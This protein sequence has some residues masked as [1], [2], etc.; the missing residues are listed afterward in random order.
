MGL[1]PANAT[2]I[3]GFALTADVTNVFSTSAQVTGRVFAADHAAPTPSNLIVAVNDMGLAYDDA[4]ARVPDVVGLGAAGDIG[5]LTIAPGTYHW[6]TAV[7]IPSNVTLSGS[8]TDSWIFQIGLTLSMTAGATIVLK[9][10]AL[11]K[12][13]Y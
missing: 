12:N 10:G 6:A 11:A 9:G 5:G 3:T 7:S 8:A 4:A 1:S 13:V 2:D